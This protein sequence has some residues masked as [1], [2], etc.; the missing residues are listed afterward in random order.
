[1]GPAVPLAGRNARPGLLPAAVAMPRMLGLPC[2]SHSMSIQDDNCRGGGNLGDEH[3]PCRRR[4]PQ[5]T[6][7]RR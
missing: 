6:H 5:R 1:M 2:R 7:S 4:R 3:G